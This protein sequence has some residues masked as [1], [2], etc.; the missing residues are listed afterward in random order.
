V[1][2]DLK[3]NAGQKHIHIYKNDE[4][5]VINQDGTRRHNDGT[6]VKIPNKLYDWIEENFPDFQLPDDG[7]VRYGHMD[8]PIYDSEII[9]DFNDYRLNTNFS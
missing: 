8:L 5:I 4:L 6:G 9:I 1:R 3:N 2:I 7:I